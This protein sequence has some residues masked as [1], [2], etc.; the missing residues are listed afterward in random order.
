MRKTTLLAIAALLTFVALSSIPAFAGPKWDFGE[1]SWMKLDFLGQVHYSFMEDAKDEH[2]FYIR[3]ARIILNGQIMEGVKVFAETDYPNAGKDGVDADLDIQDVWV[4]VQLF[5]SNH[6][7]KGGL[8][9]LPFSFENRSSAASLLGIDYNSET[10]K[11]VNDFTWRDIGISFQ[12]SFAKR[13][14]Y[15]VGI[16]DGYDN[17]DKNSDA[18]LRFTGRVDV[19]VIGDVPTGWFY[20]QDS[21]S[22]KSYLYVGGG[23]DYQNKAT[24]VNPALPKDNEAW[25][26]DFQSGFKLNDMFHLTVNGA[27]YDWDNS[28]FNGNTA[29]AE[30]GLRYQKIIG[31]LKYSLEDP[32][33][34]SNIDNYTV[35]LQYNLKGNNIKGGIEYRWGDSN[36]WW[37]VGIQFLL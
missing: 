1:N 19:A 9:L 8:I 5:G 2:D 3:R 15:R 16:F 28:K 11:F 21:I 26:L 14:A 4:D 30:C 22:D 35:G 10:I 29:F 12:G 34:G 32:D 24:L 20:A 37:L 36:D 23:F 27:W 18:D 33:D 6:W 7:V 25:V 31:T 17:D 13:V